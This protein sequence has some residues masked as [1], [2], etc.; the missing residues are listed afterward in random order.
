MA[1]APSLALLSVPSSSSMTALSMSRWSVASKPIEP[2]AISSLTFSTAFS[3]ALA[4]VAALVAVAELDG[5][6]RAGGCAPDG[7]A[8]RPRPIIE[9]DLDL[10][11]RV[12]AGIEDLAG[13]ATRRCRPP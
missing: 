12:A 9:E 5:L 3:D 11:G 6:E 1:L 13:G 10:D 4:A 8:A 2:S 7:T